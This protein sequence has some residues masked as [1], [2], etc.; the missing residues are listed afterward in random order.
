MIRPLSRSLVLLSAGLVLT[1]ALSGCR[2]GHD[3]RAEAARPPDATKAPPPLAIDAATPGTEAA[4]AAGTA[5]AA[6]PTDER[7]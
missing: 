2:I 4:E 1:V 7:R 6:D 5:P 3:Q